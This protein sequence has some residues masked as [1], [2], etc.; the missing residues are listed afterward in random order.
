MAQIIPLSNTPNQAVRVSVTVNQQRVILNLR[1]Y[2]NYVGG[3]WV[4]DIDDSL[5][6][7]LVSDVPL[8]TGASP[9]GNILAPYDWLNIGSAFVINLNGAVSDSPDDTNLGTDFAL[10]WDSN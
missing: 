3:F 1:V 2:Y 10:L 5:G 8:L 9:A 4:M 7:E 6:N